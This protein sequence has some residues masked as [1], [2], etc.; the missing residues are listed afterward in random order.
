MAHY[1]AGSSSEWYTPRMY[2]VA[3]HDVMGSIDLDP[4]SCVEGQR[5]VRAKRFYTRDDN[6]L[7]LD[8][9]GNVW[10]NPPYSDYR[11]QAQAWVKKA[12]LEF[13]LGHVQQIVMLINVSTCYQAPMQI[14]LEAGSVCI[15]DVRIKF[16]DKDGFEMRQPPQPNMFVYLGNHHDA[17]DYFFGRF[18]VVLMSPKRI[19]RKDKQE[20]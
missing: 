10:L 15:P 5:N 8:W 14:A 12:M 17:F 1:D 11:G 2:I 4:A 7:L 13:D 16:L 6:G 9:H 19:M 20:R 18:G 3:A